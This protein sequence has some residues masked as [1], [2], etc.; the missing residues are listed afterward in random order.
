[1]SFIPSILRGGFRRAGSAPVF[2]LVV[3]IA[4]GGF[5][6]WACAPFI[7]N[8]I[9]GAEEN[10][11]SAPQ[12][13]FTREIQGLEPDEAR[14]KALPPESWDPYTQTAEI[15][16][17]DLRRALEK[18]GVPASRRDEMLARHAE[19]RAVLLRQAQ[20]AHEHKHYDGAPP[21]PLPAGL[22]VPAGL[23]IE[24]TDYLN[25]AVAYHGNRFDAASAAWERLL[26]R[27]A[28][29]R[30]LRSTWAAF[31]LGKAHLHGDRR[32]AIRWF[33]RTRELAAGGFED[34]LG[35]A[36]ASFGWEA[37]A[38]RD[39][40]RWDRALTLYAD[41][42]RTGDP[43]APRALRVA[44]RDALAAGPEALETIARSPEARAVMTTFLVSPPN[45]SWTDYPEQEPASI[46]AWLE[47]VK[48]A[49]VRDAEG[50]DRLAWVAYRAGDFRTAGEWVERAPVD[51]PMARWMK[52]KLLL[53]EG[54]LT[55]AR[56]LLDEVARTRPPAM[57]A[58]GEAMMYVYEGGEKLA[59]GP[60]AGAESAVVF[61]AQ[62]D[63]T[64]ALDRFLRTGYWLGASYVAERVLTI[65]ELKAYV[66][67]T[68]PADQA[69]L[70]QPTEEISWI[71]YA[72][73]LI[74]PPEE[75]LARDIRYLLGR[76]LARAGRY[77]EARDYLPAE[78]RPRIDA[79]AQALHKGR[80]SQSSAEERAGSL[81]RAACV[82]RWEGMELTG[83]E[84]D[85]DWTEEE[86]QYELQVYVNALEARNRNRRLKP[87]ADERK[88]EARHRVEPWKRFH[89]RYRAADLAWEA[90]ALLPNDSDAKANILATAGDL[91]RR[92][93][94][95]GRRPL[96]QGTGA[97]LRVHRAGAGGGRA[98]VV[99]G[100]GG[101]RAWV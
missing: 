7:P 77:Q 83:T 10:V 54:K 40:G 78:W 62:G 49:G 28:D 36:A 18:I 59:T 20:A 85:P 31:M 34:T 73:G 45:P 96:L 48:R 21:Q 11:L 44:C 72:G 4:A 15:D 43:L 30:R 14:F 68:W 13:W 87:S 60:E 46:Q 50:A 1:M 66:D 39:L 93:R 91:A 42:L 3:L 29:E 52:A 8:W 61:L 53:R 22:V 98:A 67:A 56:K 89:Y 32:E 41:L 76:R 16:K 70:W 58:A 99:P 101:V 65:P 88:R 82:T 6:L 81:F 47:A 38:E 26:G 71:I 90:A 55:E 5:A 84:I 2:L 9:L 100:G 94:S 27:P 51:A 57:M 69:E 37:Q 25:G 24:F 63:Y 74:H 95:Q 92:S 19:L 86:G 79:L 17:A 97:L 23:P 64:G 80:D 12:G 33:Q 75:R 35:L